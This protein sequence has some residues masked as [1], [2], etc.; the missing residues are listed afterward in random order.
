LVVSD[1]IVNAANG[2]ALDGEMDADGETGLLPSGDGIPGGDAVIKLG[3]G[4]TRRPSSRVRPT[5]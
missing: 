5:L 1:E 4:G 3:V 2:F